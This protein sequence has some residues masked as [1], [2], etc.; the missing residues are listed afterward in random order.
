LNLNPNGEH[1]DEVHCHSSHKITAHEPRP[2]CFPCLL[3]AA[4]IAACSSVLPDNA[5][6]WPPA[7][8]RKIIRDSKKEEIPDELTKRRCRMQ[9]WQVLRTMSGT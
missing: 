1:A 4:L 5:P 6:A 7:D 3:L 2:Y 8:Y 9:Y